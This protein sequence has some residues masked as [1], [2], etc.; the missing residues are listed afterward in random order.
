MLVVEACSHTATF[1]EI[2]EVAVIF[3]LD[4]LPKFVDGGYRQ[5][6]LLWRFC[7]YLEFANIGSGIVRRCPAYIMELLI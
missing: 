5:C 7:L 4:F 2:E 6:D 3:L 1:L